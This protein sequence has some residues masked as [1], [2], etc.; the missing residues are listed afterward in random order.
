MSGSVARG[1]ILRV[2]HHDYQCPSKSGNH[3]DRQMGTPGSSKC[4]QLARAVR[5]LASSWVLGV[6]W[7]CI[8]IGA[9]KDE[10]GAEMSIAQ[11]NHAA[12]TCSAIQLLSCSACL[13]AQPGSAWT[14]FSVGHTSLSAYLGGDRGEGPIE[15]HLNEW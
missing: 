2:H 4:S 10:S 9:A 5:I 11:Y 15:T 3:R 7:V 14:K 1:T 12:D 6:A 13:A 8:F